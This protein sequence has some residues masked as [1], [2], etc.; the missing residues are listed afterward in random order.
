[1]L[2]E[3]VLIDKGFIT[4]DEKKN[5]KYRFYVYPF[6]HVKK[7]SSLTPNKDNSKIKGNWICNKDYWFSTEKGYLGT[8]FNELYSALFNK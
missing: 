8:R 4:T 5:G 2:S 1:M 6:D 3:A 7:R